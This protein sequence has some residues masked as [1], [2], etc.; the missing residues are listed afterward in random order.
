[1]TAAAMM[2]RASSRMDRLIRISLFTGGSLIFLTLFA[3]AVS[4][5]MVELCRYPVG[6]CRLT[7]S[8]TR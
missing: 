7:L 8:N 4:L 2:E 3:A 5:E 6:R 1:M